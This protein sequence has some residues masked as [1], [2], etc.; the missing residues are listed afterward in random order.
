MYIDDA[1]LDCRYERGNNRF[2]YRAG[3]IIIENGCILLVTND[4][5]DYFYTVGG[6]IHFD[7]TAEQAVLREVREETGVDYEADRLVF[8]NEAFFIEECGVHRGKSFHE[9]SMYFLMKPRGTQKI[10]SDSYSCD[11]KE[12][13][14]WI[15]LG[16]LK[17]LKV[18]PE[19]L[20][21]RLDSLPQSVEYIMSDRLP[22][23]E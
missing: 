5:A 4:S 22:K 18:Y 10:H 11:G 7:E 20:A 8:I 3:A 21:E 19:F 12:T 6:A 13:L 9:I 1:E 16:E 2:V 15:P 14:K 23:A 17:S